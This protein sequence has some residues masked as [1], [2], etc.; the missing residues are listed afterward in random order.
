VLGGSLMFAAALGLLS[1]A[2]SVATALPT[3]LLA[4]VAWLAVL[5]SLFVSAQ[6]S[7]PRWVRGRGLSVFMTIFMGSMAGGA[8]LWGNVADVIGLPGALGAAAAGLALAALASARLR[9]D[10]SVSD[11]FEP[12]GHWPDPETGA[13]VGQEE[14]PVMVTV[15]YDVEPERRD[16]FLRLLQ[17]LGATRRR[18][19]AYFWSHFEDTAQ[20]GRI[21]EVFLVESWVEHLRQHARVTVSDRELQRELDVYLTAGPAR[22][23]HWVHR[24]PLREDEERNRPASRRNEP[25]A[26]PP[27]DSP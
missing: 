9:F 5:S 7:L 15:E 13:A 17:R 20:S 10:P 14:G 23:R 26:C 19:G 25:P 16:G 24:R 22:V 2:N 12:S 11:D 3:M 8:L 18:D 27:D 4:G 21:V 6:L 1:Q